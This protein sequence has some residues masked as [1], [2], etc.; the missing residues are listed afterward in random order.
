MKSAACFV[1]A[2]LVLTTARM[3][4]AQD[5]QTTWSCSKVKD[6]KTCSFD[7]TIQG[8]ITAA[9]VEGVKKALVER[10]EMMAR[11]GGWSDLWIIHL[12]S[13]GGS[14]Q[15]AFDIG[16]LLRSANATVDIGPNKQCVSA[17]VLILAGATGRFMNGRVG[18]HR[19]YFE[20]PNTDVDFNDVQKA[21]NKMSEQIRAYLR[22][23]NAS[24]RLADDMMIV[25]PERVRYLSSLELT[26]Y[27]T[28]LLGRPQPAAGAV[29]RSRLC[30]GRPECG[31]RLLGSGRAAA[32]VIK[33]SWEHLR[34]TCIAAIRTVESRN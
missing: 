6:E 17:C 28:G 26:N 16:R 24:D 19:P 20:T 1:M 3:A 2:M 32:T 13:L 30:A 23:M 12:D 10:Q 14:V 15:A 4:W 29:N 18:I 33:A 8:E 31:R 5:V 9:T 11:E 21:Y 27:G 34:S 25:P 7:I 22:E